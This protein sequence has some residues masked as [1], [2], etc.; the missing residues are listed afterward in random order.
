M[1][2][3]S[4]ML[5]SVIVAIIGSTG[6]WTAVNKFMDNRSASRKMILGLGYFQLVH[7]C[8]EYL[9]RGWISIDEYEDLNKYLF[10]PYKEMGGNGTAAALMDK[11]KALPNKES[12]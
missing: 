10:L 4:E 8:E 9:T 1:H 6:L 3:P 11:V 12:A 5:M 7:A 2:I